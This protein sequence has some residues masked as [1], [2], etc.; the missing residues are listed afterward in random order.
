MTGIFY[1][2]FSSLTTEISTLAAEQFE[3][4]CVNILKGRKSV[5]AANHFFYCL[6]AWTLSSMI[7]IDFHCSPSASVTYVK[8]WSIFVVIILWLEKALHLVHILPVFHGGIVCTLR[9]FTLENCKVLLAST[10]G[11]IFSC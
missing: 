3:E 6:I 1:Q 9:H 5:I 4:F 8:F 10:L 11:Y 7:D 2:V